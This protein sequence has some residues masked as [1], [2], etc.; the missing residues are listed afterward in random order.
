MSGQKPLAMTPESR[1]T[2]RKEGEVVATG[3]NLDSLI[4]VASALRL[5]QEAADVRQTST[6]G[7]G[8]S[9]CKGISHLITLS[10]PHCTVREQ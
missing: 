10:L 2:E 5:R 8:V 1:A 3:G 4:L 7:R 9:V 6:R